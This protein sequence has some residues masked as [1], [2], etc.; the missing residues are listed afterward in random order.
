MTIVARETT[1][2]IGEREVGSGHP[3]FVVG[4]VGLVHDG[5][6]GLAHAFIDA[7][8]G[9][10]ADA[11]KFQTHLA[12][13]ESTPQEPFRVPF[14]RQDE[15]RYDYWRR[16]SFTED[17][18]CGLAEHARERGLVFLSSPFSL[19]AV[20]LLERVGVPAWKVGSGEVSNIELLERM[21][22]TRL[23]V[24]LSS[25]M[26]STQELDDS[27]SAIRSAGGAVAIF[28]ATSV[29]PAPPDRVG[30]NV[31]DEL[32]IRYRCPV[33]LSDHSGTIYASLAA[34]TLRANL[35]EVHVTL[36]REMFGPDVSASVTVGELRKLCDGIRFI[37][38]A[39]ANPVDKDVVA[40]EL[41]PVRQV[42]TKSVV[43]RTNLPAGIVLARE[44]LAVK[45]PGTGIPGNK[46]PT[47]VGR[48]L[49]RSLQADE[50]LSEGDV[51]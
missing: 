47:L 16:T 21:A 2:R 20:Q 32:R 36:S 5:S 13:A 14:S 42:F 1:I 6:L 4:E 51:E 35:I 30:L 26:S 33:G 38:R 45:K 28:Q 29:Y 39:L 3:T 31:L 7:V 15:S 41:E 24:L 25:G 12:E 22:K 44:H 34:V 8:A 18:W 23:P 40:E 11:V 48:R 46:L 37:E 9:T 19:E 10:G 17:Q 50:P 49:V 43:A 27:V